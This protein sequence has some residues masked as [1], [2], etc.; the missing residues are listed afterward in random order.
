MTNVVVETVY[1]DALV[2]GTPRVQVETVYVDALVFGTPTMQVE[3]VY[4]DVLWSTQVIDG[5]NGADSSALGNRSVSRRS[6]S[7]SRS[8]A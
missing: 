3:T 2:V 6:R 5:G 8:R 4:A 7:R 1:V